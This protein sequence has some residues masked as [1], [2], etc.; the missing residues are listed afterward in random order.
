ML[1]VGV[2]KVDIT[3][4]IGD[5]YPASNGIMGLNN[6]IGG[7]VT[8]IDGRLFIRV[9]YMEDELKNCF[10]LAMADTESFTRE[11][12]T[13]LRCA[14]SQALNVPFERVRINTTHDHTSI[15]I[16][17]R[18]HE[19]LEEYGLSFI[20]VSWVEKIKKAI[21][22]AAYEA[23]NNAQP[24]NM[25]GGS[26]RVERIAANRTV[27]LKDGTVATRYGGSSKTEIKEAPEEL[28]DPDVVVIQFRDLSGEPVVTIFNY[29]C[30]A[31]NYPGKKEGQL[32]VS[33]D[34]P[35]YAAEVVER[36]T[37]GAA[38][39]IQGACGNLG[40]GKYGI[41]CSLETSKT[42]GNELAGGVFRALERSVNYPSGQIK[43]CNWKERVELRQDLPTL[44]EAKKQLEEMIKTGVR[45]SGVWQAAALIQVLEDPDNICC[46]DMFLLNC[47]EFCLA[48]L[49][50]E[51]FIE[52][53]LAVKG[54]SPFPVTMVGAYYDSTLWYIP[55]RK[56]FIHG[57]Y[58]AAGGWS[59]TAPGASEQL[60]RSLIQRFCM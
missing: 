18:A 17:L 54:A 13:G 25:S 42:M 48:G 43:L 36:E 33:P 9:M 37:G 35:G 59:Y 31:T 56:A 28:I 47:G 40:T 39:F 10:I 38:F 8:S 58:E 52:S 44:D 32:L 23:K 16:N 51:S 55:T 6:G 45:D 14:V 5:L 4:N 20:D 22:K 2:G 34:F 26:A 30:H 24:V 21:V 53:A 60:T 50:A 19:I 3:P 15:R 49:P 57:G 27:Y 41:E 1:S 46:C 12:D 7:H 29:A 11:M